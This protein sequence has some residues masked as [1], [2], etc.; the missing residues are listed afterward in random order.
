MNVCLCAAAHWRN[1]LSKQDI[2][3]GIDRMTAALNEAFGLSQFGDQT[4]D[5]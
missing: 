5:L 4:R 1:G 3:V 2:F